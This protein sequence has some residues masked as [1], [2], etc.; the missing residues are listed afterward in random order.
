M[1]ES[2]ARKMACRLPACIEVDDLVQ[3]GM[4]GLLDAIDRYDGDRENAQKQFK[5]YSYLRIR[6]EMIDGLRRLDT[7]SRRMRL[8]HGKDIRH[9][10][11]DIDHHDISGHDGDPFDALVCVRMIKKISALSGR[12]KEI[13]YML[14]SGMTKKDVGDAFAIS[15]GRVCQIQNSVI[16]TITL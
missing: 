8:R 6:G 12:E 2:I 11:D 16:E 7:A 10:H 4:I 1:V 14:C 9:M 13:I 5:S 3:D 15:S